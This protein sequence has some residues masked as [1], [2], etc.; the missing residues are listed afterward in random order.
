MVALV[1]IEEK[2]ASELK[3]KRGERKKTG[4][5]EAVY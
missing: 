5:E 2:L 4:Q 1:N 3:K